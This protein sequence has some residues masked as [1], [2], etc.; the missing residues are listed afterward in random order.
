MSLEQ[1]Q[2]EYRIVA[3]LTAGRPIFLELTNEPVEVVAG[4][5]VANGEGPCSTTC[6]GNWPG[7]NITTEAMT[8]IVYL[9]DVNPDLLGCGPLEQRAIAAVERVNIGK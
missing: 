2:P 1:G 5:P 7:T 4:C 6:G 8:Q 9:W 3:I